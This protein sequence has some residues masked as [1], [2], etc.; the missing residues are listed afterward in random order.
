MIP[1]HATKPTTP[2]TPTTT[3]LLQTLAMLVP[4][5]VLVLGLEPVLV[6][7]LEPVLVPVLVMMLLK[8][9]NLEII[10]SRLSLRLSPP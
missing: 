9:V 6:L 7:V 8:R 4:V 1:S 3:I 10:P 5:L 2:Q